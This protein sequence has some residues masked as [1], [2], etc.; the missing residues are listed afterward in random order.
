MSQRR[1]GEALA[2]HHEARQTFEQIGESVSVGIAW[3]QIGIVHQET[4]HYDEAEKAYQAALRIEVQSGDR[5]GEAST[6]CQLGNLYDSNGRIEEA[7]RFYQH[8]ATV[9]RELNNLAGEGRTYCNL[10]DTLIELGRHDEARR[11]ILRAIECDQPLGHAAEPWKTFR[12]L[13]KIEQAAGNMAAAS[14]ARE[15]AI[16]AYLAY[17]RDDGE[18]LSASAQFF[19]L[20]AQAIAENQIS[21]SEPQLSQLQRN[22]DLPAG[23]KALLPKLQAILHGARDPSLATDPDLDYD[24]AAELQLLLEHL[25]RGPKA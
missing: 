25:A 9:Y 23:L 22:A 13:T 3:H 5:S 15:R 20:V 18:N 8:G 10:A 24:D 19:G 2:A 11:E 17:R 16:G 7:V 1:Y 14:A 21:A 6:L 4:G 12:T